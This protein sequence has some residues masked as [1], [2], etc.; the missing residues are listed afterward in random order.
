MPA[1]RIQ[2]IEGKRLPS[3]MR[4]PGIPHTHR[5]HTWLHRLRESF[6]FDQAFVLLLQ[7]YLLWSRRHRNTPGDDWHAGCRALS[8]YLHE[9]CATVVSLLRRH[10]LFQY[11]LEFRRNHRLSSSRL[12]AHRR[13]FSFPRRAA[14]QQLVATVPGSRLLVTFHFGD[15]VYGL[16]E[17]A[18]AEPAGRRV[19]VLSLSRGADSYFHNLHQ[20]FG[21]DA[22]GLRAELL[23]S[24]QTAASLSA[25]LR[26][27][28]CTLVL[29]C[30]L[31]VAFGVPTQIDFLRRRAWFPRGAATLAGVNRLPLIPVLCYFDGC[32]HQLVVAPQ[33]EVVPAAHETLAQCIKRTTQQL[34]SFFES[35][36]LLAPEQ[37]RYLPLLPQ[38][39][40]SYSGQTAVAA[41]KEKESDHDN[42]C[43]HD[44]N[45]Q[46]HTAV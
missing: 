22:Q 30:D 29:F 41:R 39:F 2:A 40:A 24:E 18:S 1:N 26:R 28:P 34:V 32:R 42:G 15:Y 31:P 4:R 7:L 10:Q 46:A 38:Y 14:F 27:E 35:Y 12:R 16:N 17:I 23:S 5:W 25:L 6:V 36:F 20:G 8:V 45:K 19:Y 44:R 11:R 3:R 9:P 13:S 21:A 37:W 43:T 33:M